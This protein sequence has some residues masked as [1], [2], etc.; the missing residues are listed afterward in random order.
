MLIVCPSCSTSYDLS[1]KALG[2]GR[3]VR[4]AKCKTT[5]FATAEAPAEAPVAALAAAATAATAAEP[6]A[7][8]EPPPPKSN[9]P[10]IDEVADD[11][12]G[13]FTVDGVLP[14]DLNEPDA[15]AGAAEAETADPFAVA[16]S[17][18]I[19]PG[20]EE[21]GPS[22][23]PDANEPEN[24]EIQAARRARRAE[25]QRKKKRGL[26]GMLLS[27]PFLILVLLAAVVAAIQWRQAVVKHLPQTASLFAMLGMPVNLRGLEFAGVKSTGEFHD[28]MMVLVVEGTIVNVTRQT[29]DVPR[30]RFAMRNGAGHE[31]Y[32]WTALPGKA[33]L[34]SGEALP[35]KSRLASPPP[36]GKEVIVRFFNRRD[37]VAGAR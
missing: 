35:F 27:L 6:A 31:V 13:S 15:A 30:L 22:F 19:V 10:P 11:S 14:P 18:S 28:G 12:F 26:V 17:P 2:A 34:A 32:A 24:I 16:D 7:A 23:D 4:C 9:L 20:A 5:W 21:D 8:P 33:Q 1:A 25:A 3:S 36:D 29:L 37:V